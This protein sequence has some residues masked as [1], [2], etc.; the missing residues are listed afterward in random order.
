M[1]PLDLLLL[2]AL[3]VTNLPQRHPLDPDAAWWRDRALHPAPADTAPPTAAEL[4][5]GVTIN[6]EEYPS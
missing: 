1:T 4:S 6:T 5:A 3:I 2:G